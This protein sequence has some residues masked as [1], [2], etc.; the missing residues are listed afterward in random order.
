MISINSNY[1]IYIKGVF[2]IG[3]KKAP[4]GAFDKT[5]TNLT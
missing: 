4:V 5:K 2:M 1:Y 3:N